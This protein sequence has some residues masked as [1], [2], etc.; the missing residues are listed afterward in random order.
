[1]WSCL[2]Q[3]YAGQITKAKHFGIFCDAFNS[4]SIVV[5]TIL[6]CKVISEIIEEQVTGI[7]DSSDNIQTAM[8]ASTAP[9]SKDTASTPNSSSL[10]LPRRYSC[11]SSRYS[12][13]LR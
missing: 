2:R 12:E 10:P 9:A 3:F 6:D 1:M 7:L 8:S 11:R 13:P 5:V 4:V